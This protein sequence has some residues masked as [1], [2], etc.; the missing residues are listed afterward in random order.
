MGLGPTE[1]NPAFEYECEYRFAEYERGERFPF[2]WGGKAPH[3]WFWSFSN[4]YSMKRES[5]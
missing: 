4:R 1:P 3:F 2:G 5:F